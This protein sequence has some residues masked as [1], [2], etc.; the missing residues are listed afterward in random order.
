MVQI[1]VIEYRIFE[2]NIGK[3]VDSYYEFNSS[4]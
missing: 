4:Q 1:D 2:S 3:Q